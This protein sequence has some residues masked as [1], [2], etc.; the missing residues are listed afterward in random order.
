MANLSHTSPALKKA[1]FKLIGQG[2]DNKTIR[3]RQH[4]STSTLKRLR[5]EYNTRK[6]T[7][8]QG[9]ES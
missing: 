5:R 3:E 1:I 6:Q 4:I 7:G 9:K 2:L 8:E